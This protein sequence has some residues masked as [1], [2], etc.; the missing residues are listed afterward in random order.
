MRDDAG[1]WVSSPARLRSFDS[2]LT[3]LVD[4]V[5][6]PEVVAVREVLRSWRFYDQLRTDA[7]APARAPQVGTRTPVLAHDG[8]DL[9]AAL[10]TVR[11]LGRGDELDAAVSRAFP[12]S[13][14]AVHADDGRFELALH[15]D[16]LLRPLTG[17]ELSDGTLRYLFL[18]AALLSPRPPA[19]LVL[20]EP[21]TS[22]HPD[23][24]PALGAL[25]HA[26]A[27]ETQVVVVTHATP[28]VEALRD[29]TT[30]GAADLPGPGDLL[31]VELVRT[32]F[33]ETTVAGREGLLDQPPWT[34]PRR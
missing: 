9:A 4:P 10:E 19:L 13:R 33:G 6:T 22:L 8:A 5:G 1:R 25:V 17:A 3:E 24:L 2:V 34:W 21:E 32:P 30:S 18:V 14:L 7:G 16:G 11:D 26:A 27:R 23:L 28:L 31:E 20:N 12:G 15:Q 29:A